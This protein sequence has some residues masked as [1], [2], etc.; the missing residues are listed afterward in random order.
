MFDD[1]LG[2]R[3]WELADYLAKKECLTFVHDSRSGIK[4]H[5]SFQEW[6]NPT[7]FATFHNSLLCCKNTGSLC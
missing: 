4:S 3:Q 7:I 5:L 6:N 1:Q 2:I